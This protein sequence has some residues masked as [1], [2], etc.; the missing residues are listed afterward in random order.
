MKR[1]FDALEARFV[2]FAGFSEAPRVGKHILNAWV[3]GMAW[4]PDDAMTVC[5]ILHG[6]NINELNTAATDAWVQ[7]FGGDEN[8]CLIEQ[9]FLV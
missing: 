7:S 4:M 2:D 6:G 8:A 3:W 5:N 9:Q 1:L